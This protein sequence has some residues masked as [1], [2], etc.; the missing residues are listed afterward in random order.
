MAHRAEALANRY[1]QLN[2]ELIA[3]LEQCSVEQWRALCANERWPV[4]VT[5]HHVA[6][7][8]NLNV[9][10]LSGAARGVPWPAIA[11]DVVDQGN[12]EHAL[13]YADCTKAE[14]IDLL[15]RTGT[16]VS[17]LIRQLD[18][19]QLDRA[20]PALWRGNA[21]LSVAQCVEGHLIGHIRDHLASIRGAIESR[22]G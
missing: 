14:T 12:A 3:V 16:A 22:R 7:M 11:M 2:N 19:Q 6:A 8:T 4:G 10:L 18:E 13:Q 1:E 9:E 15:T 17:T 20:W 5:A 21:L